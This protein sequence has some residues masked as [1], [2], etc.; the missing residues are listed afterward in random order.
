MQIRTH[1]NFG[2]NGLRVQGIHMERPIDRFVAVLQSDPGL[3]YL[4]GFALGLKAGSPDVLTVNDVHR[5]LKSLTEEHGLAEAFLIPGLFHF[6]VAHYEGIAAELAMLLDGAAQETVNS[7]QE[8]RRIGSDEVKAL[9]SDELLRPLEKI[10]NELSEWGPEHLADNQRFAAEL[11]A[12]WEDK[13]PKSYWRE[14]QRYTPFPC[15]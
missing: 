4:A 12:L 7:L 9:L 5:R 13:F 8:H 14:W 2:M 10:F 11:R 6:M 3:H 15:D 1:C